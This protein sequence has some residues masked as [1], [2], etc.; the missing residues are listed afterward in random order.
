MQIF[1]NKIGLIHFI[2]IGGIGMSGIA[3][4]LINLG[5]KVSG[6][7]LSDN[8]NTMRLKKLNITHLHVFP[9]S[10]KVGTPAARMPQV[11]LEIRRNRAKELRGLGKK[12]Y[13]NL[14]E[15]QVSRKH[16]VLIETDNGI[17]KTENNF[18]ARIKDSYKGKLLTVI[19]KTIN[20]NQLVVS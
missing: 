5:F 9:Y 14:L 17:G 10:E 16:N 7:D 11:P 4:V 20:N 6:S 1:N 19:P 3:E 12:N 2:G 13:Q 8:A 18:E 15:K